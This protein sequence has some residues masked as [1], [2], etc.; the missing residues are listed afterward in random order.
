MPRRPGATAGTRSVADDLRRWREN[1]GP[2]GAAVVVADAGGLVDVM[3]DGL[4]DME[5][6]IAL[7]ADHRFEIGSI[8]KS[9]T[10]IA[11]LRAAE[12]GRLELHDPVH[13]LLPWFRAGPRTAGITI[14]HLL[15]HTGGIPNGGDASDASAFDVWA[16]R[17]A[18]VLPPGTGYWYSN[19]GYKALGLLAATAADAPFPSVLQ[20]EALEAFGMDDAL[21][22]VRRCDRDRAAVGYEPEPFAYPRSLARRVPAPEIEITMGDGSV[23]A[24][25]QDMGHY[26]VGLLRMLAGSGN[27]AASPLGPASIAALTGRHVRTG[28]GKWYGYGLGIR[29]G[30][31]GWTIGHGGD[32]LG[33]GASLLCDPTAGLA[34]V[35]LANLRAA[36]TRDLAR[37]VLAARVAARAGLPAPV[38]EPPRSAI[39]PAASRRFSGPAGQIILGLDSRGPYVERDG[40]SRRLIDRGGDRFEVDD[41]RMGRYLM[42]FES[43][44]GRPTRVVHGPDVFRGE[45]A[46]GSRFAPVRGAVARPRGDAFLGAYHTHNPWRRAVDVLRRDGRLI[47]VEDDGEEAE[48][49]HLGSGR[50]RIGRERNPERMTFDAVVD[51]RAL[52]ATA[53]GVPLVRRD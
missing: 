10:A 38:F 31:G 4:A 26:A 13:R 9:L 42:R 34:V 3:T 28:P 48:L 52:R 23:A 33:F 39:I 35:V 15:T 45:G 37:H 7:R 51:G 47:L 18:D 43:S 40:A 22:S 27:E 24:T 14:H 6:K 8:S 17:D 36:P 16:L 12:R 30:Q 50:F 5:R 2:P 29:H 46:G 11:V 19:A 49:V 20:R 41:P 1:A 32:T 21:P 25:P 44:A 53:G